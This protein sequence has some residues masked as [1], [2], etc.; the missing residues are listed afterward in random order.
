MDERHFSV[1]LFTSGSETLLTRNET[2][3]QVGNMVFIV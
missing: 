2:E 3:I 1:L